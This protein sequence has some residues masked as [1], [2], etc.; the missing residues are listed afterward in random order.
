MLAAV[1]VHALFTALILYPLYRIARWAEQER[2]VRG[3]GDMPDPEKLR[4]RWFLG[5]LIWQTVFAWLVAGLADFPAQ[6]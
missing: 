1:L 4:F 3:M 5:W 2:W 6:H